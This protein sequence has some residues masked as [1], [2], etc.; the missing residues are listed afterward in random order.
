MDIIKMT[1]KDFMKFPRKKWDEEIE[2]D[3][4]V[5][6]PKEIN[7]LQVWW[8]YIQKFLSEHIKLFAKPEIYNGMHESGYRC[9]SFV[10]IRGGEPICLSSGRSD[11]LCLDGIG[12]FGKNWLDENGEVPK[13]IPPSGW[14][15]E[16]LPKSGFLHF[17][18]NN[19]IINE[20][21]MSTFEVYATGKRQ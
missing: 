2:F 13:L 21:D 3:S 6:V 7:C 10:L 20:Y 11:V 9:M 14:T 19:K 8:Y 4:F 12:G 1:R 15:A 18:S 16:C 5:V 17:W